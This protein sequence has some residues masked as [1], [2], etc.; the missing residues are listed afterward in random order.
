[1][2]PKVALDG[3]FKFQYATIDQALAAIYDST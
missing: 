1:V 2:L 3:G